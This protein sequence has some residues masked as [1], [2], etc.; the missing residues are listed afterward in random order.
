MF[1]ELATVMI[2]T[3]LF[4]RCPNTNRVPYIITCL[5]RSSYSA[6]CGCSKLTMRSKCA[7]ASIINP[8]RIN[9]PK[10]HPRGDLGRLWHH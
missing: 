7:R 3:Q 2:S 5:S 9:M 8:S 6:H 10:G 4:A 1:A